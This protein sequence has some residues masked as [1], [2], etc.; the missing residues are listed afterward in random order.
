MF[1][2]R[3]IVVKTGELYA[4]PDSPRIPSVD[5]WPY[6]PWLDCFSSVMNSSS[7]SGS[8]FFPNHT[9]DECIRWLIITKTLCWSQFRSRNCPVIFTHAWNIGLEENVFVF[10]WRSM[11]LAI[12]TENSS[13]P[14]SYYLAPT[15][16][17][18]GIVFPLAFFLNGVD[19]VRTTWIFEN[20]NIFSWKNAK[21]RVLKELNCCLDKN[22]RQS[23]NT[24]SSKQ[25]DIFWV[26]ALSL[27]GN[28]IKLFN[29]PDYL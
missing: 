3:Q 1:V 11:Q 22:E 14:S 20:R 9:K 24:T 25:Y 23:A 10:G 17:L 28:W 15:L 6:W 5:A 4:W 8:I 18:T 12:C 26:E 19:Y 2:D 21:E 27:H 7:S 29:R 16:S 13:L